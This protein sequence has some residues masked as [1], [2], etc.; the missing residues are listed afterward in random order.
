MRYQFFNKNPLGNL[1]EDCV[2]RA[3]SGALNL[4]YYEI[5]NKLH[6]IGSLFECE[7]L[8][9][10]CYKHLLDYVFGLTRYEEFKGMSIKEFAEIFNKGVYIIRVEGHLTFVENG[11]LK[12]IWD[13]S[14]EKVD[15]VWKVN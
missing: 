11:V 1:E 2:C 8:C 7:F 10:C 12:D 15:I 4:N 5:Q 6:L 3:I 9:E 13:C 14:R